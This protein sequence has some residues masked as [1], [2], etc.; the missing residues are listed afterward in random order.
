MSHLIFEK[1][2]FWD[3]SLKGFVVLQRKI[4]TAKEPFCSVSGK[5]FRYFVISSIKM[6]K[7][8]EMINNLNN[9]SHE[10]MVNSIIMPL[11][12]VDKL[13]FSCV[14]HKVSTKITKKQMC[15]EKILLFC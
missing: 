1:Q 9:D 12:S 7:D 2:W 14:R 6:I 11:H 10:I 3:G 8:D 4:C 15:G 5:F 13:Y